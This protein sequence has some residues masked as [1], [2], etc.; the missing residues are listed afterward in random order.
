[1]SK[2]IIK[3]AISVYIQEEKSDYAVMLNGAWGSGKTYF[4]KKRTNRLFTRRI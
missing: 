1:M 3:N 2:E 4:V